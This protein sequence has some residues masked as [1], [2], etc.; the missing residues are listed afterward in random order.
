MTVTTRDLAA[1]LFAVVDAVLKASTADAKDHHKA[2]LASHA[3]SP[4]ARNA[5]VYA[6]QLEQHL[7]WWRSTW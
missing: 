4:E 6:R 3:L 7:G 1:L 5:G 2:L